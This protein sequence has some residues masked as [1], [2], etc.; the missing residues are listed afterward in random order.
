MS[1]QV[2]SNNLEIFTYS[3][4][5]IFLDMQQQI[6]RLQSVVLRLASHVDN[7]NHQS[8]ISNHSPEP[9]EPNIKHERIEDVRK[10]CCLLTSKIKTTI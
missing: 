1:P 5:I 6:D 4:E 10:L 2:E 9:I 7:L 3:I 8:D